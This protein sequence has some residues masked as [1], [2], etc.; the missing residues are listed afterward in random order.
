[1]DRIT[2]ILT[3]ICKGKRPFFILFSKTDCS[4]LV[5]VCQSFLTSCSIWAAAS[6]YSPCRKAMISATVLLPS[7]R[8]QTSAAELVE[9]NGSGLIKMIEKQLTIKFFQHVS[10][11]LAWDKLI[12]SA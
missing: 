12:H 7:Q 9:I 3:A 2:E 10:V 4:G 8:F 11:P 5:K 6:G 1:M